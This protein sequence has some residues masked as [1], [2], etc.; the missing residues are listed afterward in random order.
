MYRSNNDDHYKVVGAHGTV[1]EQE[2]ESHFDN[3]SSDDD[4]T[5]KGRIKFPKNKLYGRDK[6]LETL[7]NIFC[8]GLSSFEAQDSNAQVE[9]TPSRV[10]FLSGYSGVGKSTLVKEFVKQAQSKSSSESILHF[11]GKFSEQSSSA[12]PFSAITDVFAQMTHELGKKKSDHNKNQVQCKILSE[13]RNSDLLAANADCDRVLRGTFPI[14]AKLLDA[15][16]NGND[17]SNNKSKGEVGGA[18]TM[19]AVKQSVLHLLSVISSPLNRPL[20]LF[21]DDLQW[22][23]A[24]SLD[25]L[26]FLLS[27][28]AR[29]NNALFICAYRSNEVGKDHPFANIMESVV[30]SAKGT[31][32][33]V[34]TIDLFNLSQEVITQFIADSICKGEEVEDISELAEV[35]YQKT[36]GNIFCVMQALDE[37][38]RKNA[39]Y[40][41]MMCFEWRWAVSKVELS[42]TISDD[43]VETVMGKIKELSD[44]I[45]HMLIVMAYIPNTLEVT[46][47]TELMKYN[48]LALDESKVSQLLKEACEEALLMRSNESGNYMF[49]H[50]RVREASRGSIKDEDKD[51]LLLHLSHVLQKLATKG[52]ETEWCLFVAVDLLNSLPVGKTNCN[53]LARLNSRVSVIARNRGIIEK[54]NDLLHQGLQC[55]KSSGKMWDDYTLTLSLLNDAIPCSRNLGHFDKAM[56]AIDD[57]L[58]NAKTLDDKFVAYINQFMV[59]CDASR[60]YWTAIE[61]GLKIL[62]MYGYNIPLH[63]TKADVI[64]QDMK[65]KLALKNRPFTCLAEIPVKNHPI[66]ELF[67]SVCESALY[68]S[69]ERLMAVLVKKL[70]VRVIEGGMGKEFP[71]TFSILAVL[72]QKKGMF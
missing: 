57:V 17:A 64:K 36:M 58:T 52:S 18:P 35:V 59:K 12:T 71:L 13:I 41:D 47:L 27:N 4:E 55:L 54:Q 9:D 30:E 3:R 31:E 38:V 1:A 48:S 69:Q 16:G 63:P 42:T 37:L 21:L 39:L 19:N 66:F 46:I 34:E 25:L 2:D 32:Q 53:D 65:L 44:E 6:E 60:D 11:S 61:D 33:L 51:H 50:D 62:N 29:L 56:V 72:E 67:S 70:I 68:T 26:S 5:E 22:A 8:H 45:Q 14:L 24:P 15:S 10:V 40:Y 49:I 20:V 23:D 7:Q 28:H 43:V